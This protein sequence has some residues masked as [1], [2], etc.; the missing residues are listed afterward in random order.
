MEIPFSKEKEKERNMRHT[1]REYIFPAIQRLV[2]SYLHVRTYIAG[3]AAITE[4]FRDVDV[5]ILTERGQRKDVV[6]VMLSHL[7][8]FEEC[9]VDQSPTAL[10]GIPNLNKVATVHR[11]IE[12]PIQVMVWEDL[13]ADEDNEPDILNLLKEFDLSVHAYAY[14]LLDIYKRR[15]QHPQATLPGNPIEVLRFTTPHSTLRR[16]ITLSDRYDTKLNW[17]YITEL[18]RRIVAIAEQRALQQIADLGI[19]PPQGL[20]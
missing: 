15:L 3:S 7:H 19:Q 6:E 8:T 12:V 20:M 4:D 17:E 11:H 14:A 2:P 13:Q 9:I 1:Q 10:Y 5:W 16:Y 18:A